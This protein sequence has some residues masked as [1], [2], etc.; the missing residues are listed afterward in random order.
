MADTIYNKFVE[1]L[2]NAD[3]DLGVVTLKAALISNA[4]TIDAADVY[5]DEVGGPETNEIS[6]T[7]YTA[8]GATL[9]SVAWSETGGVVTLDAANPQ[10]TSATF[11]ARYLAIY[12]DTPAS[13]KHLICIMDFGSDQSVNNGTFEYQFHANGI[14]QIS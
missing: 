11:T 3:I 6:G 2:G 13:N 4:Y 10:W 9:G 7:G 5:F 1:H 8:G 14:I 12:N